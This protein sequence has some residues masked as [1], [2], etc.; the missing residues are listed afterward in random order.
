MQ[1]LK[2][3]IVFITGATSGIGEACAIEFASQGAKLILCARRE[4]KLK[5]LAEN[6]TKTYHCKTHCVVADVSHREQVTQSIMELS[7]EWVD[8]DILINNAGLACGLEK[9]HDLP[10]DDIDTMID[11]NLK[12]LLYV[13]HA[14]L[15][16]MV[17]RNKGHIIHMGS[18]AGHQTYPGGNV[19]S[20]TKH[21]VKGINESIKIDL[22]GTDIRVSSIDPGMVET[23]FSKVRFRGDVDRADSVYAGF[24]PLVGKDIAEIAVF[25]A[26]RP[27]HVNI[28]D[29]I[30]MSVA[31]S[32]VYDV[33]REIE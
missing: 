19:Y 23:N 31:Q 4:Q 11:T 25:I 10:L 13:N 5:A 6:L 14:V 1:S 32:S 20:A 27:S 9:F 8:I 12:G 3:K 15:Q 21:A 16:N 26:T 7:K 2:D 18:I 28:S 33:H 30:V 22:T 17:A 29:T 24:Q